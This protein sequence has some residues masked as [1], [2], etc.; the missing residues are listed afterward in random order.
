MIETSGVFVDWI[1]CTALKSTAN[2]YFREF[3]GMQYTYAKGGGYSHSL[4]VEYYPS[5]IRH[6]FTPRNED[7][8]SV[9]VLPGK[10]WSFFRNKFGNE[11]ALRVAVLAARFSQ[12]FTR[13]DLSCD[14][15]DKGKAAMELYDIIADEKK[16]GVSTFGRRKTSIVR[17]DG[18]TSYIGSRF[19]PLMLRVYDKFAESKGEIPATRIEFELKGDYAHA[20]QNDFITH[21]HSLRASGIFTALLMKIRDWEDIPAIN[22][23]TYGEAHQL[24]LEPRLDEDHWMEWVRRQV[25]PGLSG[26]PGS[27]QYDRA[28]WLNDILA[29]ILRERSE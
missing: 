17:S 11:G 21:R 18:C 8:N 2:G 4:S 12:A 28:L 13:I 19:S 23:L 14:I 3:M 5:N 1:T 26:S 24:H 15:M 6:Y 22:E 20:I 9:F 16:R 7:A 29:E 27:E 10:S 25:I